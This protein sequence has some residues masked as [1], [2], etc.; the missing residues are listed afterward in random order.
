MNL[1]ALKV[2]DFTGQNIY[3]GID[4]HL[5]SWTISIYSDEFELKTFTQPPEVGLLE[6]HLRTHYPNALF[7]LAYE[8]GFSGFWMQ[9]AFSS[10]GLN[11]VV[12]HPADVPG[13]DKDRKRKTDQVDS[14]KIAKGLK[15]NELNAVFIPDEELES[16]RLLVRRRLKI[17]KTLTMSKN[18]IKSF[19]KYKGIG[20]PDA[21]KE[22]NWS[23]G[24]MEWLNCL[25][26]TESSSQAALQSYIREVMFLMDQLKQI[27][28]AIKSLS[29]QSRYCNR[30]RLLTSVPSI[31]ILTAM[32]ILTELGDITRFKN[33]DHLC[34]YCGLT[35]NCYS[36]GQTERITGMSRR[37]NCIVKTALIEC[38]WM[39]I[40][41]DPGLL[42][43]YKQ[44]LPRMNANKAIVKVSRKLLNRIA[45]VL[46]QQQEYVV[47]L[48]A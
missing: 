3:V 22:G 30:V 1:K 17:V 37:G 16:D 41:K 39:A 33:T 15:N 29:E 7:H 24:F 47:G 36:S 48:V 26:F 32:I 38:S 10:K 8:A 45:Y 20:I 18:R 31:G 9:R 42:L 21:Y 2:T 19:L 43:Y 11:C 46:R 34:S 25:C 35:P 28:N 13:S 5:K 44:L 27:D 40:R 6:K 23:K 14:R 12:V 4:T